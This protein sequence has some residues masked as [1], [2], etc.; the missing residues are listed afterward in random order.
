LKP[1]SDVLSTDLYELTML[2]AYFSSGLRDEASFELFI[3]TMPARRNFIVAAGLE[4]VLS[5]LET[6][7]FSSREVAFLAGTDRF[8]ED[9]L[10]RL[11]E[12]R[13]TGDVDAVPEG[14]IVFRDEPLI[15]VRAPL[16]EAQLVETRLMALVHFETAIASKAARCVL[17]APDKVIVD[18]G[19]RRAHGLEAGLLAARASYVAGFAGTS[20]VLAG[21][22]F[23]VPLFG[24]MAHSFVQAHD[25]EEDAFLAFA[26]ANRDRPTLLIDTYDTE[27]GAERVVAVA[28]TLAREGIAIGGAR[29]DSGDIAAHARAVRGI[30][31]RAGL[32]EVRIF[33][34]GGLDEDALRDLARSGAP[35]DGFGVGSKVTTSADA[36]Y[37]DCAYKLVEYAGRPRRKRSEGKST[38]PGRKQ[39]MRHFARDGVMAFDVVTLD[40]ERGEGTPLLVPAMRGGVRVGPAE[41]LAETRQRA[42]RSLATLPPDLR[43]LD[44]APPYRVDISPSLVELADRFDRGAT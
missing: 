8:S 38:W 21:A 19:V 36:P 29:L 32:H 9:F 17:A 31:D 25:R 30:L 7:R 5:F 6:M 41:P 2:Q 43:D 35:I 12:L 24:T 44:A 42:A 15:R 23:G 4:Q 33:A 40:G 28:P 13:F 27:R 10:E 1:E 34:S 26:R 3:R 16:P 18:F 37:F 14:T 39:V 22:C 20:T 11:S